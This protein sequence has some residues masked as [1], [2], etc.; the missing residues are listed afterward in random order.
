ML[1]LKFSGIQIHTSFVLSKNT[2]LLSFVWTNE[3][4]RIVCSI[5][6]TLLFSS[7]TMNMNKISVIL[8]KI[9]PW[10]FLHSWDIIS[11]HQNNSNSRWWQIYQHIY[12]SNLS[13]YLSFNLLPQFSICISTGLFFPLNIHQFIYPWIYLSTNSSIFYPILYVSTAFSIYQPFYPSIY[14]FFKSIY[15]HIYF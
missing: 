1:V 13:T 6:W 10:H 12:V 15:Q 4:S 5:Y 7:W 11:L 9:L 8:Q 3:H 2:Y 14:H